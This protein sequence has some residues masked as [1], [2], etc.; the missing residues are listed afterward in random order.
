MGGTYHQFPP[1]RLAF[2]DANGLRLSN[3]S[4]QVNHGRPDVTMSER[5]SRSEQDKSVVPRCRAAVWQ[6][7]VMTDLN[8]LIRPGSSL[9]LIAANWI[10]NHGDIVGTARDRDTHALVPFLAIRCDPN[11]ALVKACTQK[12]TL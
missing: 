4:G 11:G 1:F 2:R 3:Q 10:N 12:E 5:A 9:Y 8:T 7:G 6:D